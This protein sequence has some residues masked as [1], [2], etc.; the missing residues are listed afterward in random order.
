MYKRYK[1]EFNFY[2]KS[3]F[4]KIDTVKKK[5]LMSVYSYLIKYSVDNKL[6][7]SAAKLHSMYK[8]HHPGV[9]LSYFKELLI[10]LEKMGLI[11]INKSK[12]IRT[13]FIPRM[14]GKMAS[15]KIIAPIDMPNLEDDSHSC[16]IESSSNT[17]T[18]T[19]STQ[20]SFGEI[21]AP[22]E[23]ICVAKSI[24][25]EMRIRNHIII[26]NVLKKLKGRENI[27]RTG[28]FKY[29]TKVII[30]KKAEFEI[31]VRESLRFNRVKKAKRDAQSGSFNN[32]HQRNYSHQEFVDME[33]KL[34]GWA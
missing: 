2:E 26:K 21:V 11:T 34:L 14:A 13:F 16:N 1:I 17:N 27:N 12:K 15:E 30:E 8:N 9:S 24:L 10:E 19:S 28:M 18:L 6:T 4:N 20:N 3:T 23:L 7:I 5:K 33:L 29:I 25:K 31:W 22:V 32:Y